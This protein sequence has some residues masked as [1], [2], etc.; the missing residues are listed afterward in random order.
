LAGAAYH[1][2]APRE[3]YA[4]RPLPILRSRDFRTRFSILKAMSVANVE[5]AD[6]GEEPIF[7]TVLRPY[8]SLS[9][10]GFALVMGVFVAGTF[11]IGLAFWLM[12]AWPVV[13]F[14]GLDILALQIA[15]RLNYRS[16]RRAEEIS[17]TRARLSVRRI[18]P[19]GAESE[20]RFNPYWARLEIDRHPEI[21]VTRLRIA[22]HGVRSTIGAFLGPRQREEF[23]N[24][25]AAALAA[26][27]SGR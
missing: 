25:F 3:H 1:L 14:C 24:A 9:P 7:A 27:R 10:N 22:S 11:T 20:E 5:T 12:G 4:P 2:C 16:A 19:S 23:A 8:R 17:L 6:A 13:G 15:F 21:G 26:A 18:A